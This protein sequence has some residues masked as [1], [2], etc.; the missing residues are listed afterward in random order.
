MNKDRMTG[1]VRQGHDAM[2]LICAAGFALLLVAGCTAHEP[3]P[4]EERG[5]PADRS[6]PEVFSSTGNAGTVAGRIDGGSTGGRQSGDSGGDGQAGGEDSS[7]SS[8]ARINPASLGSGIQRRSIERSET[9]STAQ[10]QEQD[11]SQDRDQDQEEDRP[12]THRVSRGETLYSIAWMYDLDYRRLAAA[13]EL[14]PPY[15]IYPGQE[16]SLTEDQVSRRDMQAASGESS[17]A[18]RRPAEARENRR[19]APVDTRQREGVSWQW[20]ADARVSG[21]FAGDRQGLD[22]A[23]REGQPVYAAADGDVVYAGEGIQG[24]GNLIILRHSG[25]HLSAYMYNSRLLVS[26]GDSILAGDKIAEA[27]RAPDGNE[28]LHFEIR[29]DGKP[30]DPSR[31]LPSRG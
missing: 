10:E 6:P 18:G 24:T 19:R 31:Y 20:P 29:V 16:L 25:G 1:T 23:V 5:S 12:D 26:Q 21:R 7:V 30:V 22:I 9:D 15:T 2:W 17:P 3:A 11:Q 14:S 4:V 13:N 27:G 28:R 8:G